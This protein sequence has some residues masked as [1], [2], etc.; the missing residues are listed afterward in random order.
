MVIL[1]RSAHAHAETPLNSLLNIAHNDDDTANFMA[2]TMS[3]EGYATSW[4]HADSDHF[5]RTT[6]SQHYYSRESLDI[7]LTPTKSISP[8][9][10]SA[11]SPTRS[12]H[13]KWRESSVPATSVVHNGSIADSETL[14]EPNF[15]ET[16]LRA[17]CDLDVRCRSYYGCL[18]EAKLGYYY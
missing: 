4:D 18:S 16:V 15:D 10:S 8:P 2:A 14:A 13:L 11:E 6:P 1:V 9:R 17:L 3:E 5:D 7:P 12:T